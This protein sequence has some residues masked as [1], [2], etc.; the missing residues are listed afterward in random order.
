MRTGVRPE[1][2]PA[3]GTGEALHAGL[4]AADGDG[5]G[6]RQQPRILPP[7]HVQRF[8]QPA[9]I[10]PARRKADHRDAIIARDMPGHDVIGRRV[11]RFGDVLEVNAVLAAIGNRNSPAPRAWRLPEPAIPPAQEALRPARR[12]RS[13]R[14][15]NAP[16]ATDRSA[17]SRSRLR[18]AFSGVARSSASTRWLAESSISLLNSTVMALSPLGKRRGGADVAAMVPQNSSSPFFAQTNVLVTPPVALDAMSVPRK[19]RPPIHPTRS[20][21]SRCP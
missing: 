18:S 6:R 13:G 7:R 19:M 5:A 4:H 11:K 9:E 14:D 17:P 15:R 20:L 8:F 2:M 12:S 21:P 1:E 10:G 16:A 3:A